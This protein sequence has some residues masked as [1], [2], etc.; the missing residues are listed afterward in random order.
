[1]L[2]ILNFLLLKA[3]ALVV[4]CLKYAASDGKEGISAGDAQALQ[5]AITDAGAKNTAQEKAVSNEEKLTD[6]RDQTMGKAHDLLRKT[7]DAAQS[8]YGKDNKV[9]NKEFHVGGP[10]LNAV[11]TMGTEL[12]YMK[13]VATDNLADL[14]KHG[15]KDSDITSF[16]T[17]STDLDTNSANQKDARKVQ[18]AATA[19]RDAAVKNLRKAINQVQKAAK[20]VFQNQ[21]SVLIEFESIS[22]GHGGG[23][24]QPPTPPADQTKPPAK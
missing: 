7:L 2:E 18:K 20:V 16:D 11:K 17:I 12:K 4:V 8:E 23:K 24:A 13:S 14:K 10:K 9:R 1:M 6:L 22:D 19:D 21:P 3:K 5:A 15:F